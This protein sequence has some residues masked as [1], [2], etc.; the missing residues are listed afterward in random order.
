MLLIISIHFFAFCHGF[1]FFICL[2]FSF[3]CFFRFLGFGFFRFGFLPFIFARFGWFFGVGFCWLCQ[4]CRFSRAFCFSVRFGVSC[5]FVCRWRSCFSFLVCAS[6]LCFGSLVRQFG[7]FACNPPPNYIF[8]LDITFSMRL[9][10]PVLPEER[11][12]L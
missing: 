3:C 5:W 1:T 11:M 10:S 9:F 12:I 8:L 6:F 2:L 7:R 4:W